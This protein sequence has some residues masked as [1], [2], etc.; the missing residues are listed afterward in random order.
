MLKVT[1][2]IVMDVMVANT[3][4]KEKRT[5]HS[6]ADDAVYTLCSFH[7]SVAAFAH[8]TTILLKNKRK[9]AS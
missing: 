2:S 5:T 8:T 6:I 3:I 7:V 9:L 1:T 4:I